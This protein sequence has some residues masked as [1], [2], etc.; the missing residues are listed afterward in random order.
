MLLENQKCKRGV[1]VAP[2]LI[3]QRTNL[4]RT[5]AD[6]VHIPFD[7]MTEELVLYS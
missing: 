5:P 3:W 6:V 4:A 2:L 1:Q 7:A